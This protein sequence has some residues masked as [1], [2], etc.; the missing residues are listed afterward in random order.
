MPTT[1]SEHAL[2]D[3]C[4]KVVAHLESS[5]ETQGQ[6]A[7]RA[8][9]RRE[10]VSLLVNDSYKSSPSYEVIIKIAN[11]INLKPQWVPVEKS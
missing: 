11:A 9:V 2:S 1:V 4:E 5:G 8:G 6:L 3:L 10:M 7:S